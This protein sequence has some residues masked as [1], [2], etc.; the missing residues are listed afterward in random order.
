MAEENKV[1][2][3]DD[4]TNLNETL[5]NEEEQ[6]DINLQTDE[7][8]QINN[9]LQKDV[10]E[11]VKKN[12][13]SS[14]KKILFGLIGFLLLLI[15]IGVV[16]FLLGFFTPEEKKEESKPVE[17][18][19]E[20]TKEE[21]SYKFD[22]KD[23]NSKKLNEQLASLTN[24]NLNQEK[25]EELEKKEDEK[26]L[27]EEQKRK[28]EELLA[29]QEA[30]LQK[31]RVALEETKLQLENEKAQL[32][33]LKEQALIVKE[34]LLSKQ[35]T[36]TAEKIKEIEEKENTVQKKNENI[37]KESNAPDGF[38][39]FISVAKIKGDLYKKYLDKV[40]AINPNIILC[41]DDKNRIEIYYGP[42]KDENTRKNLLEKL[43][44]N[45][46]SESYELE[47]TKEEFDIRCNY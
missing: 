40:V 4:T 33:I 20:I 28:E 21:E 44:K 38:L 9:N 1:L 2:E 25:N 15:V 42:F 34:E 30:T 27:I 26:R 46:F 13:K 12:K 10:E 3:N 6:V 37:T 35:N 17:Q 8:L 24:K 16:L 32:E 11:F 47:F 19:Q 36:E 45:K 41:R 29:Q 23:I 22:I 31:E 5:V 39:K 7:N 43:I 14:L 18:K